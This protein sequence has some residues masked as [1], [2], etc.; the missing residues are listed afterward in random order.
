MKLI[1]TLFAA[2][3]A[4]LMVSAT[5]TPVFAA[6]A[7]AGYKLTLVAPIAT[8]GSVIAKDTLWKCGTDTCTTGAANSRPAIVCAVAARKIGKLASF[9]A[10]GSEFDAA[11][12]EACNAKAK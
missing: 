1:S 8:P 3:M 7:G 6:P 10:N 5:A 4:V 2:F 11:A 9:T 12:L